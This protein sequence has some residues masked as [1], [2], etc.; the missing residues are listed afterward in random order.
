[1]KWKINPLE[2]F[3]KFRSFKI[4][5]LKSNIPVT[6]SEY[7]SQFSGMEQSFSNGLSNMDQNLTGTVLWRKF[8]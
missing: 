2:S 4:E 6:T 7:L 3:R 8:L 5:K 1:M